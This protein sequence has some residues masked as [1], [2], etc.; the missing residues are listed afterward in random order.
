MELM[1]RIYV[2]LWDKDVA[3]GYSQFCATLKSQG[4]HLGDFDMKIPTHSVAANAILVSSD[5]AFA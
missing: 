4:I 2:P 1:L 3:T 5:R